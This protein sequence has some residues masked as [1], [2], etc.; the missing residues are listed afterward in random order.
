MKLIKP[1]AICLILI[2]LPGIVHSQENFLKGYVIT[3]ENDTIHGLIDYRQW[4]N[5]P[6]SFFF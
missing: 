2:I 1:F 4:V 5:S 6:T 3:K